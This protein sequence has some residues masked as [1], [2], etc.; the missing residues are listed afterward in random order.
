[1]E[2][3][4]V[5]AESGHPYGACSV[6]VQATKQITKFLTGLVDLF[7]FVPGR[8]HE[9]GKDVTKRQ[10]VSSQLLALIHLT[11]VQCQIPSYPPVDL[12]S[13]VPGRTHEFGKDVTKQQVV[14]SQRISYPTHNSHSHKVSD[15][16]T[17]LDEDG[18]AT[19]PNDQLLQVTNL[20]NTLLS[21][22]LWHLMCCTFPHTWNPVSRRRRQLAPRVPTNRKQIRR[23]NYASI[24]TLYHQRRTDAVFSAPKH[25]D[26]RPIRAV[27]S[28]DWGL[29]EPITD[30][31]VGSTIRLMGNSF[32]RLNKCT[33]RMLRR[34]SANALVLGL[35]MPQLG[36]QFHDTLADGFAFADDW[37]GCA[38]SQACLKE[39]LEA[40]EVKLERA[41]G[42]STDRQK[43]LS[44]LLIKEVRKRSTL[45]MTIC[46]SSTS[47]ALEQDSSYKSA[48]SGLHIGHTHSSSSAVP[49]M[50]CR[51]CD[52]R[53]KRYYY[54]TSARWTH[55]NFQSEQESW[56]DTIGWPDGSNGDTVTVLIVSIDRP[57]CWQFPARKSVQ[58]F[59]AFWYRL[60][61]L[62]GKTSAEISKPLH[63]INNSQITRIDQILLNQTGTIIEMSQTQYTTG[64]D[65]ENPRQST[66]GLKFVFCSFNLLKISSVS[67]RI[68]K[69][70]DYRIQ[71]VW[72][73]CELLRKVTRKPLRVTLY[74]ISIDV[75]NDDPKNLSE[76]NRTVKMARYS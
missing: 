54:S 44:T 5:P 61:P 67:I 20:A 70:R 47:R 65:S 69:S 34:F 8:T 22:S 72:L 52:M 32:P 48:Q 38:E 2:L 31:E 19:R 42:G 71:N 62:T 57:A 4:L 51:T 23:V 36:Y 49:D 35:P 59:S 50:S 76:G 63:I 3:L 41:A 75:V 30:E 17:P 25:V 15:F 43:Y 45:D 6:D 37:V 39:K 29:I 27:L 24:Q 9:F 26:N 7:S 16:P 1:M 46:F 74:G 66:V 14:S 56:S 28:S 64:E 21:T 55:L 18:S 40:A 60:T 12:F 33:P 11:M 10:V 58:C 13:F 68:R 53:G 73:N